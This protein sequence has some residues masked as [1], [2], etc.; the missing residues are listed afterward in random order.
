MLKRA[1]SVIRLHKHTHAL[2][3]AKRAHT[4]LHRRSGPGTVI[5]TDIFTCPHLHNTCPLVHTD[6][7]TSPRPPT[8]TPAHTYS[9]ARPHT[10]SQTLSPGHSHTHAHFHPPTLSHPHIHAT[11]ATHRRT[12]ATTTTHAHAH[13]HSNARWSVVVG[14]TEMSPAT[15]LLEVGHGLVTGRLGGP[16]TVRPWLVALDLPSILYCTSITE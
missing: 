10:L 8:H 16:T 9:N 12:H 14:Q 15:S 3:T 5:H 2:H 11:R 6:A 13:T 4:H 7:H 1:R